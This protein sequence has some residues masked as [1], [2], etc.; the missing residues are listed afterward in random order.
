MTRKYP[1]YDGNHCFDYYWQDGN[2][3]TYTNWANSEPQSCAN[4]VLSTVSV[5]INT[6]KWYASSVV[7]I[8]NNS[9]VVNWAP[10][11]CK[12]PAQA[13]K[14]VDH[15][16]GTQGFMLPLYNP[17]YYALTK[18]CYY[19]VYVMPDNITNGYI[20]NKDSCASAT[21]DL[22]LSHFTAQIPEEASFM[23]RFNDYGGTVSYIGLFYSTS[24]NSWN[25]FDGSTLN[26]THWDTGYP[27][28]PTNNQCA[29]YVYPNGGQTQVESN[30]DGYPKWRNFPCD[31]SKVG[32]NTVT[33]FCQAPAVF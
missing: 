11:V 27:Q 7:S 30:T 18:K 1:N 10:L 25:W 21:K 29:G 28:D 26:V 17:A 15:V 2:N 20:V 9:G 31:T 24:T 22:T 16:N 3:L 5:N 4:N 33:I 23:A 6:G 19:N 8:V 13:P 32:H 12:V 14:C